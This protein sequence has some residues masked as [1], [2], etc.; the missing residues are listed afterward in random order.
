MNERINECAFCNAIHENAQALLN[1]NNTII[2]DECVNCVIEW[3]NKHEK[4]PSKYQPVIEM[5]LEGSQ[6]YCS[7]CKKSQHTVKKVVAGPEVYICDECIGLCVEILEEHG[8][9]LL[10]DRISKE[11]ET[12]SSIVRLITFPPLLY[13]T[14]IALITTFINLLTS[15]FPSSRIKAHLE[16][17]GY[18]VRLVLNVPQAEKINFQKFL[19]DYAEVLL[20]KKLIQQILSYSEITVELQEQLQMTGLIKDSDRSESSILKTEQLTQLYTALGWVLL[21]ETEDI[22]EIFTTKL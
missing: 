2:C 7:F 14:G 16:L 9:D 8:L 13:Q 22:P 11:A 6:V 19:D 4:L 10:Q 15:K 21:R 17:N 1:N 18:S 3:L 12:E 20:G 5:V